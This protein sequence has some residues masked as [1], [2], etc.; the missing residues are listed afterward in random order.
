MTPAGRDPAMNGRNA[1]A[2]S[3]RMSDGKTWLISNSHQ[4]YEGGV[5]WYEAAMQSGEGLHMA[6]ALFPG[7]PFILLGHNSNLGWTNTVNGPDLI[8]VYKL[9]LNERAPDIA[10]TG[11]GCRSKR[12]GSGCLSGSGPS[13]CLFPRRCIMQFRD[14]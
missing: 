6:G 2:A 7:S 1:F 12:P 5:A 8:D 4:P 10:L 14:P 3:R 13:L 9:T 11:S